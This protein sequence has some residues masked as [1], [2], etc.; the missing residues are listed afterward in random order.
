MR[1][2]LSEAPV[3]DPIST[4]RG[5]AITAG[6]QRRPN[7][8]LAQR[9]AGALGQI[10]IRIG[11]AEKVSLLARGGTRRV[12]GALYIASVQLLIRRLA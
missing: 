10:L 3:Q 12:G 11:Q 4:S 9:A 8:Q 5:I 7:V 2:Q 1:R 6:V